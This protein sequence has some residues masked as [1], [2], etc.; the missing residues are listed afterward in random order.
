MESSILNPKNGSQKSFYGKAKVVS[1]PNGQTLYSYNTVIMTKKPN[2]DY[3][4]HWDGGDYGKYGWS[5][6]T[7]RHIAAFSGMNKNQFLSLELV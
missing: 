1:G 6:T 7:G 4:R 2:G 5:N 3:I